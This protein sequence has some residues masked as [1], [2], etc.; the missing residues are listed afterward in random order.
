M[1]SQ[2]LSNLTLIKSRMQGKYGHRGSTSMHASTTR[3]IKLTVREWDF[4]IL[5]FLTISSTLSRVIIVQSLNGGAR[6]ACTAGGHMHDTIY[7]HARSLEITFQTPV[8]WLPSGLY[9]FS[10]IRTK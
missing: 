8:T 4:A 9:M 1:I 3:K 10:Y 5:V 6:M 2:T 7:G